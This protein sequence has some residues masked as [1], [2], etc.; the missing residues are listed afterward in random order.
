[1][2]RVC[3][4][5]EKVCVCFA[6]YLA[7]RWRGVRVWREKRAYASQGAS[8]ERGA[9]ACASQ[10]AWRTVARLSVPGLAFMSPEIGPA[11]LG[12]V[13][14]WSAGPPRAADPTLSPSFLSLLHSLLPLS[15]PR[16][17]RLAV[18]GW[19]PPSS[20]LPPLGRRQAGPRCASRAKRLCSKMHISCPP[21]ARGPWR[22]SGI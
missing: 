17:R 6:G 21:V 15:H 1:M 5:C 9:C 18:P 4:W 11:F 3:A 2:A 20:F 12:A 14:V 16:V 22:A 13:P 8:R 10:G 19:S 7:A